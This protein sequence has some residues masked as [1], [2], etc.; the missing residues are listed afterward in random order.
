MPVAWIGF[1]SAGGEQI[2]AASGS[3]ATHVPSAS[4]FAS[5]ILDATEIV[6]VTDTTADPRFAEH[7]L[8]LGPP[9]VRFYAAA[10]LGNGGT[11]SILDREPRTLTAE[12]VGLFLAIARHASR[13]IERRD[14][15]TEANERFREF[16]EQTTD[17]GEKCL[18]AGMDDYLAK[19]TRHEDLERALARYFT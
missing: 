17:L 12:Q 8:V 15:L 14:E 5:R 19:P 3:K 16:F 1:V 9:H 18:A 6:A 7:P 2:V 13:E 4:S 11:L 10:P